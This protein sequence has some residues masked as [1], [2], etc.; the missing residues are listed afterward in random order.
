V[1]VLL[2]AFLI[3]APN[4]NWSASC[5]GQFMPGNRATSTHCKVDWLGP[6]AVMEAVCER[7][8]STSAGKWVSMCLS[9]SPQHH[10]YFCWAITATSRHLYLFPKLTLSRSRP[11]DASN[12]G[13]RM[14]RGEAREGDGEHSRS[15]GES[16]SEMRLRRF[17]LETADSPNSSRLSCNNNNNSS[18]LLQ[19]NSCY[20]Q[21]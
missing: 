17:S 7:K 15:E 2:H 18:H 21:Q 20:W 10:H 11:R 4:G 6:R 8:N 1:A 9:P 5:L 16:Y 19:T 13:V 3:W 12:C 14:G